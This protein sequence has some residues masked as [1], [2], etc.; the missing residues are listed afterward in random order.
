VLLEDAGAL[1]DLG[2]RGVPVAALADGEFQRILGRRR[3]DGADECRER[4]G[5]RYRV[6]FHLY[7][8]WLAFFA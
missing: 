6:G 5:A 1:P 2:H 8:P 7:P 3:T 4:E